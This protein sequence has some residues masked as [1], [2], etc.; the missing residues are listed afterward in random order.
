MHTDEQR[1]KK[2]QAR[3]EIAHCTTTLSSTTLSFFKSLSSPRV[4]AY[5]KALA[6]LG[7]SWPRLPSLYSS[8]SLALLPL[9]VRPSPLW[10]QVMLVSE[11]QYARSMYHQGHNTLLFVFSF[12]F[13]S[14]LVFCLCDHS[15][16]TT[17]TLT[18]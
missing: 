17:A 2:A 11:Q 12:F 14:S 15:G 8:L 18:L 6:C 4:E 5:D 16:A 7:L 13:F 9:Y 10:W 3:E 1:H